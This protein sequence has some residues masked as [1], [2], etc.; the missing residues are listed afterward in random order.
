MDGS[1]ALVVVLD[2]DPTGTQ[3]ATDVTVLLEY[4]ANALVE[5]LAAERRVYVQTNSRALAEPDAVVLA[6]R[7]RAL[8]REAEQRIGTEIT[9]VLRG[10]STLRG[11][12]FAET[13]VFLDEDGVMLFVPAFPDGGRQTRDGIHYVRTDEG[14]VPV[15]DTEYATDPV[16]GFSTSDLRAFAARAGRA[17]I[18]VGLDAVRSGGVERALAEAPPGAVVIPDVEE[19]ADIRRI[20][21]D[22]TGARRSRKVVVRAAAPLA[23][24]IADAA[25]D[26]QIA[27]ESLR[28]AGR[29]LVVCGSHTTGALAQ[30]HALARLIGPPTEIDANR[31]LAGPAAEGRRAAAAERARRRPMPVDFVTT[32]RE[33]RA[34]HNMLEHGAAVM[35]ALVTAADVLASEAGIVI[36]K[37]GI[38][39]AEV[40]RRCLG[41]RRA[42]VLGQLEPGVSLWHVA[43]ADG[44]TVPCVIVPGNMGTPDVLATFSSTAVAE[45]LE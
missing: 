39:S 28:G 11:H 25:S 13:E 18:P 10:D 23:A 2:D 40:A 3:A 1:N 5:V 27:P 21:A 6:E 44:R 26:G 45:P 16:F 20:A 34:E 9:V 15:A 19:T 38:T 7:I 17:P 36:A 33:R 42:R 29:A 4:D 22:A 8:V 41:A 12:V 30:I 43:A 14:M 32:Q 35:D 37:G 24:E 31:A